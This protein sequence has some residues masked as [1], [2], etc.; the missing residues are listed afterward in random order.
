ML[1]GTCGSLPKSTKQVLNI[2]LFTLKNRSNQHL[3]RFVSAFVLLGFDIPRSFLA[4]I[5]VSSHREH[6]PSQL[7][8]QQSQSPL[9]T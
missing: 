6:I 5:F 1:I 4:A 3:S 9:K 8:Q 2:T 7:Q